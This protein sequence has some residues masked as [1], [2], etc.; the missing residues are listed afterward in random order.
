MEN[1]CWQI[2]TIMLGIAKG[3]SLD[4]DEWETTI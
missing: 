4:L 2:F 3:F 1:G